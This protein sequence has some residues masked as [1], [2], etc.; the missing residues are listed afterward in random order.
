M[1]TILLGHV[2]ACVRRQRPDTNSR[3]SKSAGGR[4]KPLSICGK[5]CFV[6]IMAVATHQ[7]FAQNSCSFS[8]PQTTYSPVVNVP[9]S[10]GV[11]SEIPRGTF[12]LSSK[13]SIRCNF[14]ITQNPIM[15]DITLTT[16]LSLAPGFT[17]VWAT[18]YPGIGV[19]FVLW[20]GQTLKSKTSPAIAEANGPND[21]IDKN[22]FVYS[23]LGPL[24][25]SIRLVKTGPIAPGTFPG[26]QI[27][28]DQAVQGYVPSNKGNVFLFNSTTR[29]G[30]LSLGVLQILVKKSTC[31]LSAS[32]VNRNITL[33]TLQLKDVPA[34]SG[35]FGRMENFT[36]TA[37]CKDAATAY[38]KFS[39]QPSTV[40]GT[41]FASTG[42]AK[43]LGLHLGTPYGDV[44]ANGRDDQRTFSVDASSGVA[45]L[46][47]EVGYA[48]GAEAV[49]TGDFQSKVTVTLSYD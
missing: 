28:Y 31:D 3:V 47:V 9:G 1:V 25:T 46:P 11:G 18:G 8:A 41:L 13:T 29:I 12:N 36:I 40:A 2:L 21:G 24:N 27:A 15:R 49:T 26:A 30:T 32:D 10:L 14:Q 45:Q 48:R 7:A 33:D 23:A 5:S 17:D 34:G 38:F 19:R 37:N 44:P 6:L 20:N 22:L 35:K 4:A 16:P 42:T 39:G 43:G